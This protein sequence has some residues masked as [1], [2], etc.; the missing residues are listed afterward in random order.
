M[1]RINGGGVDGKTSKRRQRAAAVFKLLD[2]WQRKKRRGVGERGS[3]HLLPFLFCVLGR[4]SWGQFCLLASS[5]SSF[6]SAYTFPRRRLAAGMNRSLEGKKSPQSRSLPPAPPSLSFLPRFLDE[7]GFPG[8][9]R[10][11]SPS[12]SFF[13]FPLS[14]FLSPIAVDPLK[15]LP[16]FSLCPPFP[17]PLSCLF[18][19]P[20]SSSLHFYLSSG[21]PLSFLAFSAGVPFLI[22]RR[23]P[24]PLFPT[25]TRLASPIPPL[26]PKLHWL[27]VGGGRAGVRPILASPS[28]P[29]RPAASLS[30]SFSSSSPHLP[31]HITI[32]PTGITGE[33]EEEEE[34]GRRSEAKDFSPSDGKLPPL[35][36][37]LSLTVF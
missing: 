8:R 25:Y 33:E 30:S 4:G 3:I 11:L 12:S 27:C 6:S 34:K 2:D 10:S 17:P 31:N 35:V 18:L 5:S 22:S 32:S 9:S 28:P 16:L 24:S 26:P 15:V 13:F 36:F 20:S 23:S 29:S 7:E 19:L 21:F 1:R 14:P 37:F